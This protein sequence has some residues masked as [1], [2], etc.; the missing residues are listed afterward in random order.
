MPFGIAFIV[1]VISFCFVSSGNS[2]TFAVIVFVIVFPASISKF[3]GFDTKS[4]SSGRLASILTFLAVTFDLFVTSTVNVTSCSSYTVSL[5][6]FADTSISIF[7]GV[8]NFI[9][10]A[11]PSWLPIFTVYVLSIDLFAPK[12]AGISILYVNFVTV[13]SVSFANVIL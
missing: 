4:N 5:I 9:D 8:S 12:F 1:V 3:S 11:L 2:F 10:T 13:L 7:C 6:A